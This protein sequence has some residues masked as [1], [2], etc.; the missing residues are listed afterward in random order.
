MTTRTKT[1]PVTKAKPAAKKKTRLRIVRGDKPQ[2]KHLPPPPDDDEAPG[3][4]VSDLYLSKR[5]TVWRWA[6]I[7]LLPPPKRLGGTTRWRLADCP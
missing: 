6:R 7:G 1:K 3:E 5:S 4:Y 2:A